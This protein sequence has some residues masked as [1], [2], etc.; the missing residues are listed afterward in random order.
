MRYTST[1]E[2]LCSLQNIPVSPLLLPPSYL[3]AHP[4][5]CAARMVYMLREYQL[6]TRSFVTAA[7]EEFWKKVVQ[8]SINNHACISRVRV[9]DRV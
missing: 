3:V 9:G 4:T 7:T 1:R 2:T 5:W 6:S 8:R